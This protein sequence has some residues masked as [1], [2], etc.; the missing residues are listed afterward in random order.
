MP[1]RVTHISAGTS[2]AREAQQQHNNP[3]RHIESHGTL[4]ARPH[5]AI[6]AVLVAVPF[7]RGRP[8]A[9]VREPPRWSRECLVRLADEDKVLA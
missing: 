7:R 4:R 2:P 8:E 5:Q 6:D 1:S 9:V 3:T